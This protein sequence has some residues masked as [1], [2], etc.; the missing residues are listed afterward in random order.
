MWP[1]E[2]ALAFYGMTT[3]RPELGATLDHACLQSAQP[4]RLARFLEAAYAMTAREVAGE[5]H[6]TAPGRTLIVRGGPANSVG[7]FAFAFE[8]AERLAAH[9][10]R[11][12]THATVR[13]NPSR[14]F[15]DA[16]YGFADP[17]GNVVAFG[18]REHGV[19]DDGA[20]PAR[21]QHLALRTPQVDAMA[22]FYESLGFV[23]SDRVRDGEGKLRACFLRT[24]CEHHALALFGAADARF[25]HLSCETRDTAAVIA[26]ADRMA[27]QRIPIHWGIGRHGPGNDVFFMVKDPDGNLIEISSDLEVCAAERPAGTWPHEQ[28]TLNLWGNAI[29]RS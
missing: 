16:A 15:D 13:G 18:V 8:S 20:L 10:A 28:R 3:P 23:V 21:L 11:V 2:A 22:A 5:W 27:A 25:D 9:R 19:A 24:D 29:M 6:C 1:V 4:E 14:L 7:Y 12:G 26:W 17:D